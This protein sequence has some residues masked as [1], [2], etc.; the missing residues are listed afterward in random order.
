VAVSEHQS[1]A[2]LREADSVQETVSP[3][4]S[5]RPLRVLLA[6]D[7]RAIQKLVQHILTTRGHSVEIAENGAEA[8]NLLLHQTFDV[9]LMDL[10][11]PIMGGLEA[12]AAIRKAPDAAKAC[13]PTIA[14]TLAVDGRELDECIAAGMD[15]YIRKPIVRQELI[16]M[17]ET[18]AAKHANGLVEPLE[19]IEEN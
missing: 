4:A 2:K 14:L 6:E 17:V 18:L 16:E 19:P 7:T 15:G 8:V 5:I 12:V 10:Q 13:L 11:M 1:D 3:P 9:A